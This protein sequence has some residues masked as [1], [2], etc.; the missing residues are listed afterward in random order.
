M[1]AGSRWRNEGQ[2]LGL[3]GIHILIFNIPSHFISNYRVYQESVYFHECE[4]VLRAFE[5]PA[6]CHG[7]L[8]GPWH[9]FLRASGKQLLTIGG[10]DR[11]LLWRSS[12]F[13]VLFISQKYVLK[14]EA[15][16]AVTF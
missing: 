10:G 15:F 3:G 8:W 1:R 11:K 4:L 5:G 2:P 9:N 16:L 7:R 12:D 13:L 6:L 14:L